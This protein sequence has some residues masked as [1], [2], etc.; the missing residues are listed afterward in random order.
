MKLMSGIRR[1]SQNSEERAYAYAK[2]MG[3]IRK[4]FIGNRI[5]ELTKANSIIDLDRMLFPIRTYGLLE[6]DSLH[7][8]DLLLELE[9]RITKR[10]IQKILAVVNSFSRPPQVL[11]HQLR[12]YEYA[13]LKTCFHYLS[14]G[15]TSLPLITNIGPFRTIRFDAYPNLKKMLSG[16]DF[17][18]LLEKNIDE[19][20]EAELDLLYYK[21]LIKSLNKISLS[22][23]FNIGKII[24]EEISLRNCAIVIRMRTYYKKPP[25]EILSYL[26]KLEMIVDNITIDLSAEARKILE[27]PLDSY[28]NWNFWRWKKLINPDYDGKQWKM[29]PRHF[30][31]AASHYIYRMTYRFFRRTP[32]SICSAFCYIKLNQFEQDLLISIAEGF[33]LGMSGNDVF[34]LLEISSPKDVSYPHEAMVYGGR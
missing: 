34:D 15:K 9:R 30:Q 2:A 13:D 3:I 4:T 28:E 24:A 7:D 33:G 31:N 18:F 22:D 11:I 5:S 16:T 12:S 32:L 29:D 23:R 25:E 20:T 17:E 8:R 26:L 19:F 27:I 10:T 6:K 1:H 14:T 21:H